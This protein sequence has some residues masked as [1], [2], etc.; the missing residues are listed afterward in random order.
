MRYVMRFLI[1]RVPLW[2][3]LSTPFQ[4]FLGRV[5]FRFWCP[6]NGAVPVSECIRSGMCGCDNR[7]R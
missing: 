5:Y 1:H 4:W 3:F 6:G 7:P 2:M